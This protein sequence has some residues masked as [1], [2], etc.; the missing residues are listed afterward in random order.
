ME[1][2]LLS[3]IDVS[4]IDQWLDEIFQTGSVNASDIIAGLMKGDFK[5]L[6]SL[7]SQY[8]QEVVLGNLQ[9]CKQIF[10]TLLFLGILGIYKGEIGKFEMYITEKSNLM[11]IVTNSRKY[12]LNIKKL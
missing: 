9:Q 1:E 12:V 5:E 3:L 2:E 11:L 7:L 4:Q 8:V 10:L 6:L